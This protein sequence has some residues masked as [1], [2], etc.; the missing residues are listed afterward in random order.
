MGKKKQATIEPAEFELQVLGTLWE[1]GP[2]TVRQVMDR[3]SD[4]K[5]RAYTSVLSVMQVMQ[6][7]G[8]LEVADERDGLAHIFR[9]LVSREQIAVPLLQGLVRK[10][11]GGRTQTAL[12]HLLQSDSVSH[13]EIAAMRKLLDEHEANSSQD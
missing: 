11:F 9:P 8:L 3:L 6:K 4:G 2:G 10:I 7:K 5:E 1:H 12:S 13:D